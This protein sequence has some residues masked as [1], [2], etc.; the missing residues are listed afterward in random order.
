MQEHA[1]FGLQVYGGSHLEVRFHFVAFGV[2][3][4]EGIS[5][6]F[7]QSQLVQV[8]MAFSSMMLT[9]DVYD[10]LVVNEYP[11]VVIAQEFKILALHV[12]ELG[13]DFHGESIVVSAHFDTVKATIRNGD[14]SALDVVEHGVQNGLG[15]I[16]ILEI[17]QEE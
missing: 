7:G 6:A 8:D 14:F 11:H 3:N 16:Q 1:S 5:F 10:Q 13:L 2:E 17:I 12:F 9:T 4:M 15:G